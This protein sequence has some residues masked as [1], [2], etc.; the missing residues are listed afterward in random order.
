MGEFDSTKKVDGSSSDAHVRLSETI[1][2][3]ENQKGFTDDRSRKDGIVTHAP[4]K[5]IPDLK[6]SGEEVSENYPQS[7]IL[8]SSNGQNVEANVPRLSR[9]SK[10]DTL[11]EIHDNRA[12]VLVAAD[13]FGTSNQ[14]ILQPA[15]PFNAVYPYNHVRETESGHIFE[16]DDTPGAERIKEAHRIGTFYEVHPNGDKVVRVV[17]DRFTAIVGNDNV[18]IEG[19]VNITVNG[20]CNMY[21]KG[22]FTHQ[23]DGDY[24]LL[25]AGKITSRAKGRV[26]HDWQSDFEQLSGGTISFTTPTSYSIV[27]P[28]L[29]SVTSP[30]SAFSGSVTIG[31]SLG[32]TGTSTMTGSMTM[33]ENVTAEKTVS[34][35]DLNVSGTT[36]LGVAVTSNMVNIGA[37]HTH[38]HGDPAGTT[39]VPS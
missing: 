9:G 18:L 17:G 37:T 3:V 11:T 24:N 15:N 22:D 32:V 16:S 29:F 19:S 7:S 4:R 25:V 1:D 10:L 21:T 6:G 23:V 36:A 26:L 33:K 38:T 34:V 28:S 27:A 20:D 31:G 2:R 12:E 8:S 35:V 30:T 5:I 39:S 14:K 13:S